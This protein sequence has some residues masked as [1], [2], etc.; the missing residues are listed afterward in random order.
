MFSGGIEKQHRTV[1]AYLE[2]CLSVVL[3]SLIANVRLIQYIALAYFLADF[4][5]YPMVNL[6]C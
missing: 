6:P 1:I 4:Y 5:F 3:M 2:R